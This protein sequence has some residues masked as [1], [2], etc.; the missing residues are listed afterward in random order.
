MFDNNL[1]EG[2]PDDIFT[3][4]LSL[5]ELDME[6]CKLSTLPNRC[7]LGIFTCTFRVG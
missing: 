3:S 2:L 6:K 4:L 1:A 5:K 7:V